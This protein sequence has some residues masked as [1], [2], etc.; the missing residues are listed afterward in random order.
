V[1]AMQTTTRTHARAGGAS[2]EDGHDRR[3]L[4]DGA[5]EAAEAADACVEEAVATARAATPQW[6]STAPS[7]RAGALRA[8]ATRVRS[9][10]D[11]LGELLCGTTGRLLAEATASAHV[12]AD[13]LD[14]AAVTGLGPAGRDLVGSP[15]HAD[16]TERE[17]Y[18][19]V[20]VL[21]PWNDPYPAAAGLLAAA[22]VTGNTVVHKPSE[23]SLEPGMALARLVQEALPDGVLQAVEGGADVGARI[24]R[25]ERVDVVAHVG[26]SATGAWIAATC[27]ARMAKALVENGGKDPIVV[28][29]GV[30]PDWAA[31]QIA[32]GAFTNAGQL[33]T[34]VERVYLHQGVAQ[35]VLDALVR[36]ASQLRAGDPRDPRTTLGRL[37]DERQ[38]RVVEQHVADA[39]DRGA[40][41]LHGGG[42][43]DLDGPWYAPTVL[44]DC[45]HD[46]TVMTAETFGPVAPVVTVPDWETGLRMAGE[47]AYGLAATVLTPDQAHALQAVHELEVGTVKVNAVFGGAPGGSAQPRRRSGRGAGYGPDLLLE[48]TQV[49]AVHWEPA[50]SP[51]S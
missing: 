40:T 49:K 14:E 7:D 35:D 32:V 16:W 45:T 1:H 8:A 34:S 13:L 28:D 10:A 15:G 11:E 25:D 17:P 6:R 31:G 21:T 36:H 48:L 51:R 19:V 38:L 37:V 12:A 43:L 47:G 44:A 46:M 29:T 26:S 42:R 30:D 39:V 2:S 23:R 18:G 33:C 4:V 41:C 9:A 27:G 3:A 5:D 50:P 24:V 22:L 20:A